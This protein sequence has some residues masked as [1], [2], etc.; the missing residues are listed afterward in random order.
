M[1]TYFHL[2][3]GKSLSRGAVLGLGRHA[4]TYK[5]FPA[6]I[7]PHGERYLTRIFRVDIVDRTGVTHVVA[8]RDTGLELMWDWVRLTGYPHAPSRF[9]S[10][11]AFETLD[12][13][14][15]FV[16][17]HGGA[18][19]RLWLVETAAEGF[20]AD[21]SLMRAGPMQSCLHWADLYWSQ[22]PHPRT[23]KAGEF[24]G[25]TLWEVLLTPPVTVIA[26]LDL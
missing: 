26:R 23:A 1:P 16:T 11:F 20:R 19:A 13:V 2:D 5:A 22:Q 21:M 15:E 7:S 4:A 25:R 8:D 6:G 3:R 14:A 9:Q 12:D 10:I 17:R 24:F 18:G